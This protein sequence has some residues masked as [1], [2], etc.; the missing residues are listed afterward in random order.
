[1]TD[2]SRIGRAGLS[3]LVVAALALS[4][5]ATGGPAA[6]Q[7]ESR[8]RVRMDD[9]RALSQF[10][11]CLADERGTLPETPAPHPACVQPDRDRDPYSGR[12]YVYERLSDTSYRLCAGF[13]APQA[14][15]RWFRTDSTFDEESGCLVALHLRRE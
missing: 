8:D 11:D 14:L 2:H 13:E 5:W 1:M 6:G 7:R 10:V 15:P 3:A 9:L 12:R 4:L